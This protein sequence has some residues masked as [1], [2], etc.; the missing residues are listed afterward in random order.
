[1][2]VA[3]PSDKERLEELKKRIHDE[4]YLS[5]AIKKLAQRLTED[6]INED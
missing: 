2:K 1:L 3:K 5:D 6:L 4:E